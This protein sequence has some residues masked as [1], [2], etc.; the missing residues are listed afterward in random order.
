MPMFQREI[1]ALSW[2]P[3]YRPTNRLPVDGEGVPVTLLLGTRVAYLDTVRLTRDN[4]GT[5]LA[6]KPLNP[7]TDE[8]QQ[9][10][11]V[12]FCRLDTYGAT[13]REVIYSVP[14]NDW[15]LSFTPPPEVPQGQLELPDLQ[16][17]P[18]PTHRSRRGT[19]RT[20]AACLVQLLLPL[21][22]ADVSDRAAP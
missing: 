13:L 1:A 21:W 18:A 19:Q 7:V 15:R 10:D 16:S 9:G 11:E 17:T 14:F 8:P 22:P 6:W 3:R 12:R 2:Q 4:R 20:D 5:I